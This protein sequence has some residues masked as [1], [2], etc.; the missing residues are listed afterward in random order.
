M[1]DAFVNEI[2]A[3]LSQSL[4][5]VLAQPLYAGNTPEVRQRIKETFLN[6]VKHGQMAGLLP[7]KEI[8]VRVEVDKEDPTGVTV[9]TDDP[10]LDYFLMHAGC[11]PYG[12]RI[13]V[14]ESAVLGVD[15]Q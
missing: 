8:C 7:L 5:A 4:E 13:S 10:D 11:V 15:N 14:C 2:A 3:R 12:K 6:L 1:R 9:S